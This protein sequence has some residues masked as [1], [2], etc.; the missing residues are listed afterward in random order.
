MYDVLGKVQS[1]SLVKA[2]KENSY[3]GN[4]AAG[5]KDNVSNDVSMIRHEVSNLLKTVQN[6]MIRKTRG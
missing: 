4:L 6:I 1:Q 5:L 3:L 2:S